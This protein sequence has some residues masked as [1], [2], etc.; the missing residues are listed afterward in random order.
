[1]N[2]ICRGSYIVSSFIP[3]P[4]SFDVV[5]GVGIEPTT[6]FQRDGFRDRATLSVVRPSSLWQEHST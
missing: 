5:E 2:G 1:M 3:H 4:S 6:H